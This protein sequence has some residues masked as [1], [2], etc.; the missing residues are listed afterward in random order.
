MPRGDDDM[1]WLYRDE[2][3]EET[4][5]LRPDEV[6]SMRRNDAR[7]ER[8]AGYPQGTARP[9]PATKAGPPSQPPT[10]PPA[11]PPAGRARKRRRFRPL[12][13]LGFALILWLAF[14]IGTPLYA[15]TAGTTVD[16]AAAGE[17][18]AE[19]PGSTILL[20]GSDARDD[21]SAEDRSRLR[22]GTT[23]GRRTDTMM[24]LH[25]PAE[26][27][28]V[29]LSLPRD[30][31]VQIPGRKKN[32]LNAAYAFGGA[33]LLIETIELNTG[34]RID[35]YLEVG[36]LGVVD[37]VDAVG[38]IE[39]CP[40]FDID[41]ED[42][43]LTLS[44]GCQ[45]VDGVT[46]LG[47]V[48][49]RKADSNGDFGRVERQRETI[50]AIMK[51]VAHPLTVLNPVRYWDVNMAASKSLARGEDTGLGSMAQVGTGFFSVM[52]GS[53]LSLTVPG[54]VANTSVGSSVIWDDT[55]AGEIF[56]AIAVGNTADLEKYRR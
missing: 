7:R 2:K 25:T 24:L 31:I 28:P 19:Q 49:M 13:L 5:V 3:D 50:G 35:G 33:P 44:K 10:A 22:T 47:Y 40:K 38:G 18:P 34:V 11:A 56:G 45:T 29:L 51:K 42:A 17:R 46:A 23:D 14:L 48:R 30:S 6:E 52:T 8:G 12:R 26:G 43:H 16:T 36:M 53:G 20:V 1:N 21:L 54:S 39:V 32:K 15:W 55:A 9:Q 37:V 41:D 27:E 4:S